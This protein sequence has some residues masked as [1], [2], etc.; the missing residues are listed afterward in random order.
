[1]DNAD[2]VFES[3]LG[4]SEAEQ[5]E[6]LAGI[7]AITRKDPIAPVPDK[8]NLGAKKRGGKFPLLVNL[9]GVV[10]LAG[11]IVTLSFLYRQDTSEL[12]E[13]TLNVADRKLIQEIRRENEARIHEKEREISDILDKLSGV[14][15]DLQSLQSS[16]ESRMTQRETELRER[17]SRELDEE[18]DRLIKQNLSEAAIAEQMRLFDE[19]RIARI[20]VELAAYREQLDAERLATELN[21][22]KLQEDYRSSLAGLQAERAGILEA[23]RVSEANLKAQLEEKTGEM[24]QRYEQNQ[25]ALNAAREEL[26]HLADEQDRAALVERQ[27]GGFYTLAQNHL[28]EGAPEKA[29]EALAL[30]REFL[31]TPSFQTVRAIQSQKEVH[32]AAINTLSVAVEGLLQGAIPLAPPD[33]REAEELLA[34]K[35]E[36]TALTQTIA[37]Q[38]REIEAYKS[39]GADLTRTISALRTQNTAQERDISALKSENTAQVQQIGA[40]ERDISTLRI[41]NTAQ[42]QQIGAQER[43]LSTLR[44]Q[45]T[46]QAQRISSQERDINTLRSQNTAQTQT[47]ADQTQ[48]INTLRATN[49]SLFQAMENLQKALDTARELQQ[50]QRQ[51][52]SP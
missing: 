40:Q 44:T 23:S 21:L 29:L 11:G 33:P 14:D 52:P 12:R 22:Q 7:E 4:F 31:E 18:R 47:I 35:E 26:R 15:G 9:G 37:D 43:D 13:G 49:N 28:R 36:N 25:E 27:M 32:L 5:Q 16:L 51:S 8:K 19:Q 50:T 6:I 39:Q 20:N 48:Q 41:Q 38:T 1:M 2:M 17:M 3:A 24:T 10:L 45:N 46:T 42:A 30:M 34:L